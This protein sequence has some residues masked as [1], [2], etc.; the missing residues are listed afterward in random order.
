MARG[1]YQLYFG[2]STLALQYF[3]TVPGVE[4]DADDEWINPAEVL[5]VCT[6]WV[7]EMFP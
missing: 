4:V 5:S 1:G 6:F 7:S 3:Q 2:R